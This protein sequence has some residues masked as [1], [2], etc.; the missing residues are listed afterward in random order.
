MNQLS[1]VLAVETSPMKLTSK[2]R[3]KLKASQFAGPDRSYPIN[4]PGHARAALSMVS[5]HGTSSEKKQVRARVHRKY[6]GIG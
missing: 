2:A 4:D 5:R 1:D 6:P 3:S